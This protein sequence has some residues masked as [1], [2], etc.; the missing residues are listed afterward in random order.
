MTLMNS[1]RK[2][3]NTMQVEIELNENVFGKIYDILHQ[4]VDSC[5]VLGLRKDITL[6]VASV[7]T[8]KRLLYYSLVN[9]TLFFMHTMWLS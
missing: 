5:S 4:T 6:N 9:F 7:I 1:C 2:I 3:G 8:E